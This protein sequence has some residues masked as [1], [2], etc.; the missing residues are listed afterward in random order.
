MNPL[1]LNNVESELSYAY[2]HAVAS[3]A[4]AGC[5]VTGRHSD[6]A[7]VD[8]RLTGWGPF[9]GGGFRQEVD[10]KIQLKATIAQ[11]TANGGFLSYNFRG[12]QQYD[13]LRS[14]ALSVPRILVV[15]FLPNDHAGWITHT[16]T[17]LSLHKCAYWVSLR[18]APASQ[19]ET[20]QVIKIPMAQQFNSTGLAD[21]FARISRGEVPRY[22]ENVA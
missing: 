12:I 8:A 13:D 19:N 3:H 4:R 15:L 7:G 1:T 21:L 17:A 2:L 5:E 10:I 9:P 22:E 18:G 6:N 20:Q 14:E 16:D 11:P